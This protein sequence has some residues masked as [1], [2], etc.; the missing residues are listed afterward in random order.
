MQGNKRDDVIE[1]DLQDLFGLLLAR[2][3]II[4]LAT[5][6]AGALAF[7]YSAF[8]VAPKY[9]STTSIYILSKES[10]DSLT[11]SDT[12]LAAQLTKD[13]EK[14]IL[15][16]HV[17]EQVIETFGLGEDYEDFIKRITVANDTDTRIIDITVKDE[18]PVMARNIANELR[19]VAASHI[20]TVTDVKAVN[21][22][23]R[24]NLP[25]APSEPSISLWTLIGAALGFALSA[26][27]IIVRYLL[28]DT[29]KSEDDVQKFLELSTLAL[30]PDSGTM[31]KDDRKDKKKAKK[32]GKRKKGRK[33]RH[34][35]GR[36]T[37]LEVVDIM[38][39]EGGGRRHAEY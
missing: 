19:D 21:V 2:V 35:E 28:D 37:G 38:N 34:P 32:S 1:I 33:P 17:V 13:Y 8:L 7:A 25:L 26:A 20:Q 22:A 4:L 3:W 12:Q 36:G 14:L 31:D 39:E 6:L 30:I 5:L 16:R 9:E 15:K 23:D 10:S 18:D 11:Y 24:A 27:I 29:I